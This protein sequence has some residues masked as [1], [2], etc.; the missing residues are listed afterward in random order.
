MRLLQQD[1]NPI[2]LNVANLNQY[3]T[4]DKLFVGT[5]GSKSLVHTL[6]LEF[7]IEYGLGAVPTS[8]SLGNLV[9]KSTSEGIIT[10][11][12]LNMV[13]QSWPFL[14]VPCYTE[15][16]VAPTRVKYTIPIPFALIKGIRAKDTYLLSEKCNDFYIEINGTAE[17]AVVYVHYTITPYI[18]GEK[19]TN[20][21]IPSDGYV[22]HSTDQIPANVWYNIKFM[23]QGATFLVLAKQDFAPFLDTDMLRVAVDGNV[24]IQANQIH[25]VSRTFKHINE[26]REGYTAVDDVPKCLVI[27]PFSLDKKMAKISRSSNYQMSIYT[28]SAGGYTLM[29]L[30]QVLKGVDASKAISLVKRQ[31]LTEAEVGDPN[32]TITEIDATGQIKPSAKKIYRKVYHKV[33]SQY[34]K[35]QNRA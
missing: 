4:S 26:L 27:V 30:W 31:G 32:T 9:I 6:M 19:S 15:A 14:G 33:G 22:Q 29:G 1:A 12:P 3:V 35:A 5:F 7:E 16:L 8:A 17:V 11:L 25:R 34:N 28:T 21:A 13:Y 18:L 23:P 10:T 2:N 24:M 20:I